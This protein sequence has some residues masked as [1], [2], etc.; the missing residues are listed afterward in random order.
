MQPF[1]NWESHMDMIAGGATGMP[2]KPSM[3]LSKIKG[4]FIAH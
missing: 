1:I 3:R 4:T 2:A